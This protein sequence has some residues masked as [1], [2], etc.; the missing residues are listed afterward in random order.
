M[1][2]CVYLLQVGLPVDLIG[3]HLCRLR[4]DDVGGHC[5]I[6]CPADIHPVSY[7]LHYIEKEIQLQLGGNTIINIELAVTQNHSRCV[8]LVM[9]TSCTLQITLKPD[10]HHL[11]MTVT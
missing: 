10:I 5:S 9:F 3:P 8:C 4:S 11:M 6:H 2:Y 1:M 7:L